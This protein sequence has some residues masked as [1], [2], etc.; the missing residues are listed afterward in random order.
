[1]SEKTIRPIKDW[2]KF[3]PMDR[4]H[5]VIRQDFNGNNVES[6]TACG[7]RLK[8]RSTVRV[9]ANEAAKCPK[10]VEELKKG[11]PLS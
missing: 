7:K 9:V 8:G 2:M 4:A 5:Y 10:C 1:M 6:L 11:E 3:R